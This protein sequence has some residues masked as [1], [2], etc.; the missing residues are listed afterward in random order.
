M[1]EAEEEEDVEYRSKVGGIIRSVF[2]GGYL[3][4]DF[5]EG[6]SSSISVIVF[7]ASLFSGEGGGEE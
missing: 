2:G 5:L 3:R 6:G 4:C 1:G 7:P